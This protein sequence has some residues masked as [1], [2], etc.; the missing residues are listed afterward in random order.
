MTEIQDQDYYVKLLRNGCY[1]KLFFLDKIFDWRTLVDYGCADGYLTKIIA[2]V[3]PDKKVY[4]L[5]IDKK[6]IVAARSTGELPENVV[7]GNQRMPGDVLNLSSVIH[8]EEC[9]GT[10]E[11]IDKFWEYVFYSGFKYIVVRDMMWGR[12]NNPGR[13]YPHELAAVMSWVR[14]NHKMDE[15]SR[16]KEAFSCDLS[17]YKDLIHFCLKYLY[18][19]SPNWGRE[20]M[21]DYFSFTE[22]DLMLINNRMGNKYTLEFS[23]AYTL[24]YLKQRWRQD[25]GVDIQAKTHSQIILRRK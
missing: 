7:F 24:P 6:M 22:L 21:E 18:M 11:T 16:F 14:E 3:F 25:F 8:E 13:S 2:R 19:D 5:D 20:V 9:Y 4:G 23:T 12:D 15:L 17:K 1:D 10:K